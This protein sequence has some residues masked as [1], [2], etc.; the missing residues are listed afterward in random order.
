MKYVFVF[1]VLLSI[2]SIVLASDCIESSINFYPLYYNALQLS[3]NQ[4][5]EAEYLNETHDTRGLS[6][7]LDNRQ[8]AQL[9]IINHLENLENSRKEKNYKKLNPRMSVFGNLNE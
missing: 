1:F 5:S 2:Q 8:R 3:A 4:I 7:I 9:R 6:S